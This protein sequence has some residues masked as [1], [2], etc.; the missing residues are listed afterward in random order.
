[1]V[2]WIAAVR[3]TRQKVKQ[4]EKSL[5]RPSAPQEEPASEVA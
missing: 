4:P 2:A 5:T 3:L 1:L